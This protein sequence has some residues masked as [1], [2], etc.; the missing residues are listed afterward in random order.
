MLEVIH[1]CNWIWQFVKDATTLQHKALFTIAP[2]TRPFAAAV[3]C[4]GF[5][6]FIADDVSF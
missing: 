6:L 3:A 2:D 5:E 1:V 4:S